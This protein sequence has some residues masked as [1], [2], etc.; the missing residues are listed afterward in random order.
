MIGEVVE[1]ENFTKFS[2]ILLIIFSSIW[3]LVLVYKLIKLL[4]S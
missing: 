2:A 4:Q 1:M 3:F